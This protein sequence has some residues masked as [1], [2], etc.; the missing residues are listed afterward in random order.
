MGW[1]VAKPRA[2]DADAWTTAST[3][4]AGAVG[5]TVVCLCAKSLVTMYYWRYRIRDAK[6]GGPAPGP[7]PL[8]IVGNMLRLRREYYKTLYAYVEYPASVFYVLSTPFVVAND[9]DSVRSVLGSGGVYMKPKY[10]GYRSKPVQNA[11]AST[12]GKVAAESAV[13]D[14]HADSSR[15][16]LAN[17][18]EGAFPTVKSSMEA[19]LASL[20]DAS[21]DDDA[22][23]NVR[24]SIIG[25]N[26]EVLFGI[27]P[28]GREAETS[29]IA[30][31]V[32][33]AGTEFAARMVNPLKVFASFFDN[34]R[35]VR[36]VS[37]LISL[38]RFLCK[39][40]DEPAWQTASASTGGYSGLSW[41]HAWV[42]KAGKIGKL[43]KVVGL[44]MASS[45]TVPLTAV[46]VLFLV[47]RHKEVHRQ[48]LQ[49]LEQLDVTSADDLTA[50]H[51]EKLVVADA[52]VKE[53]L[54]LYPPFPL[55]QRQAQ[56]DNVLGGIFVPDGTAAY[57]VPWLIHRNP[58]IWKNAHEFVPD[59]FRNGGPHCS[60]RGDAESDWAYLPFGRGARMCAGSLLAMS[61]LKTLLVLSVLGYDVDA[62]GSDPSAGST[63]PPLGMIPSGVSLHVTKRA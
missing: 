41:V 38:G 18:V 36:D 60:R 30:Y 5:T 4:V 43:G 33:S 50:V 45:Q 63:F 42:G 28:E 47:A 27:S 15:I 11:M 58:A 16:A 20:A 54:R 12:E 32:A 61:E 21:G 22:L 29:R 6:T 3:V 7:T 23:R 39:T 35:Y 10:F 62:S 40:L 25:L 55:I 17:M 2:S 19:L 31:M 34:I 44:L 26:L 46:W 59:R 52:V 1:L 51:L 9:I 14:P 13:Y 49:E 8:P 53:T 48:L 37:G 24:Q 56:A 57:V